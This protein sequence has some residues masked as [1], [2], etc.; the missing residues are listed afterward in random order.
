LVFFLKINFWVAR[1]VSFKAI[2]CSQNGDHTES[3]L[4]KFGWLHIRY[5]SYSIPLYSWL[6]SGSYHMTLAISNFKNSKLA[7]LGHFFHEESFV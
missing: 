2:V 7:N 6:P 1:R 5:L 3:N 4:A